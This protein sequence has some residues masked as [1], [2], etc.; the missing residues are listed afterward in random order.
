VSTP[1]TRLIERYAATGF[2]GETKAVAL[3]VL[4]LSHG[5]EVFL[6]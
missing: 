3:A 4:A 6:R 2:L 5:A 1:Q